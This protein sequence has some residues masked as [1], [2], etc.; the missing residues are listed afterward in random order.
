MFGFSNLDHKVRVLEAE[1]RTTMYRLDRARLTLDSIL[2]HDVATRWKL[3]SQYSTSG[4]DYLGIA[5]T[6]PK[7]EPATPIPAPKAGR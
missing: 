4:I 1:L 3:E 2:T 6:Q 5:L 7:A